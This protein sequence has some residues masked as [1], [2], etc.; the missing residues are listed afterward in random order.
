MR[1]AA[2]EAAARQNRV[3]RRVVRE[4]LH[5]DWKAVRERAAEAAATW[6][7]NPCRFDFCILIRTR[8]R[9][10]VKLDIDD[11]SAAKLQFDAILLVPALRAKPQRMTSRM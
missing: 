7:Q 9:L 6:T 1:A 11:V 10:D 8:F 2:V 3:C 5:R 4:S